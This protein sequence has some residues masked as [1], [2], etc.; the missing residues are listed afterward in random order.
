N[1]VRKEVARI[2]KRLLELG[3]GSLAKA[4]G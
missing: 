4:K 2:A 1:P 3:M